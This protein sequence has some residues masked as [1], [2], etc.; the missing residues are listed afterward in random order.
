MRADLVDG[1]PQKEKEEETVEENGVAIG[2]R[3]PQF[4]EF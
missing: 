1:C 4:C 2:V 3:D